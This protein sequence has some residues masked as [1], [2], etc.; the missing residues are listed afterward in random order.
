MFDL[1]YCDFQNTFQYFQTWPLSIM[2]VV[3]DVCLRLDAVSLSLPV[4]GGP[5]SYLNIVA[6]CMKCGD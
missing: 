4:C 6:L 1:T 2:I 5:R 3:L